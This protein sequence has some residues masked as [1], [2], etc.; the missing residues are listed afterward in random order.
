MKRGRYNNN[1]ENNVNKNRQTRKVIRTLLTDA[2]LMDQLQFDTMNGTNEDFIRSYL[3]EK[4]K[5]SVCEWIVD[6]LEN[7]DT[8]YLYD[9]SHVY[10]AIIFE[11]TDHAS[12]R[13]PIYYVSIECT[14]T[15]TPVSK[16]SSYTSG[17]LLWVYTLKKMSTQ[18][19]G[20][21]FFVWNKSTSDAKPY[22]LKMG[23]KSYKEYYKRPGER[24]ESQLNL[25]GEFIQHIAEIID[26]TSD[27]ALEYMDQDIDEPGTMVLFYKASG[28]MDVKG[29]MNN[30]PRSSKTISGGKRNR[31]NR[32][33]KPT[34]RK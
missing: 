29:I 3:D 17:R 2:E 25:S 23:M 32:S 9:D 5:T 26:E 13:M 12:I 11:Q 4:N 31:K 16:E 15:K 10:G 21:P 19:G 27:V 18:T 1:N 6:F 30:I 7:E 24:D 33:R 34:K 22:H 28:K 14:F 20:S 8:M